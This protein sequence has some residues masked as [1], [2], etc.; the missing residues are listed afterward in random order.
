LLRG[1]FEHD[2]RNDS[3]ARTVAVIGY[4]WTMMIIRE[5]L[6]G[7]DTFS[8]LQQQLAIVR[9]TLSSRLN[10]LVDKRVMQSSPYQDN[11]KRYKY[12]LTESGLDLY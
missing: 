1:A 8:Q 7:I 9:G 5:A 12:L 3:V 4:Q 2:K 6:L 11:P 10:N